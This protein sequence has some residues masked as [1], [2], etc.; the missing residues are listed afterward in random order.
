M[1]R[2]FDVY[3]F[4]ESFIPY[5]LKHS[6]KQKLVNFVNTNTVQITLFSTAKHYCNG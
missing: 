4:M 1:K 6:I 2:F 3:K 5:Y